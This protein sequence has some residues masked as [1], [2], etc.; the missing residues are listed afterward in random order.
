M[1]IALNQAYQ[2]IRWFDEEELSDLGAD[3]PARLVIT[4]TTTGETQAANCT[5]AQFAA[6]VFLALVGEDAGI[7][8]TAAMYEIAEPAIVA[9]PNNLRPI[10]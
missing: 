10:P 5:T 7:D 8:I 6:I 4:D 2:H 3:L 1:H 9:L